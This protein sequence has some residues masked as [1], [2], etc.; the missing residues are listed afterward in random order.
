MFGEDRV[1]GGGMR[2]RSK[3]VSE[4]G[5]QDIMKGRGG[6]GVRCL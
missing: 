4:L 3:G 1:G 6:K 5:G 2:Q